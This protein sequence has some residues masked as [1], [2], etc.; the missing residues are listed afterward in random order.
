[1]C[2]TPNLKF[3]YSSPYTRHFSLPHHAPTFSRIY[4]LNGQGRHVWQIVRQPSRHHHPQTNNLSTANHKIR[5]SVSASLPFPLPYSLPPPPLNYAFYFCLSCPPLVLKNVHVITHSTPTE[6]LHL[7]QI[8]T[9]AFLKPI[10]GRRGRSGG[11]AGVCGVDRWGCVL[12]G[13]PHTLQ[14]HRSHIL[15]LSHSAIV[16]IRYLH[17]TSWS[18]PSFVQTISVAVRQNK[19]GTSAVSNQGLNRRSSTI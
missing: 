4:P 19:F 11:E 17:T 12:N 2:R 14:L 6:V 1:M 16:S 5:S 9:Q 15:N 13:L 10:E 18:P 8:H 3:F 7:Q